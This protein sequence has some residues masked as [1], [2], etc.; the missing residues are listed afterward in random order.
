[1]LGQHTVEKIG[2]TSMSAYQDV[3]NNILMRPLNGEKV[4]AENQAKLYNR[5]F[6][7][8]AYGGITDLLLEHKKSGQPGLFQLYSNDSGSAQWRDMLD[9][10]REAMYEKN[11]ELFLDEAQLERANDFIGD[12]LSQAESC[13]VDLRRVC[14]HGHFAM[15]DMLVSL[16]EMLACIG[17]AH[18]AWNMAELLKN[19]GV[20]AK[21]I[22]LTSW[23]GDLDQDLD[24]L[25]RENFDELDITTT[26]P[27]VTG[28]ARSKAGLMSHYDRGYSEMTFSRIAVLTAAREAIIHKEFHLSSADP[29][30]IGVDKAVPI[31]RTNYDVADHLALLGMEAIHPQAAKGLRKLGIPLR[32]TNTFEPEHYGTL[33]D[34]GYISET[35]Q[36]E[37]VAGRSNVKSLEFFNQDIS[38][39]L[40]EFN[41]KLVQV[42]KKHN[43]ELLTKDYSANAVTLFLDCSNVELSRLSKELEGNYPQATITTQSVALVS[44]LGSDMKVPG[45]LSKAVTALAD[46]GISVLALQQSMRQVGIQIVVAHDCYNDAV[47]A[48]HSELVEVHDHGRAICLA[49]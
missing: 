12:R 27:I 20:N 40:V 36:V 17:E 41:E 48:L 6:V 35:P 15:P 47:S 11:A 32:L 45:I 33:I 10:V 46:K 24:E 29:R 4:S 34:T 2:G 28:Y 30:L 38:G 26:L 22:D 16:R 43:L 19:E 44:I 1:M 9:T 13:M 23:Y 7:V 37:I 14:R 18:S 5:V 25:I 8:S 21:F 49:S 31:G 39:E 42:L 3:R